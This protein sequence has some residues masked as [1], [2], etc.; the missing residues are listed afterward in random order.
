MRKRQRLNPTVHQQK[1]VVIAEA[2]A[3]NV[4]RMD[5]LVGVSR[6]RVTPGNEVI[7]S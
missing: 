2:R 4:T 5:L 7:A 3:K 6:S 1:F